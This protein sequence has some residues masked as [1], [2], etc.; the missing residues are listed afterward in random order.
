MRLTERLKQLSNPIDWSYTEK[1]LLGIGLNTS[2]FALFFLIASVSL[3][4]PEFRSASNPAA[5]TFT[6]Y[7]SLGC[8][9]MWGILFVI[10]YRLR[11][12]D[13]DAMRAALRDY[14]HATFSRYE[15]LFEVLTCDE[16]YY[17]KP[18]SLRHPLIF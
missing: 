7:F 8:M 17:R 13:P 16:A 9:A 6:W 5:L 18:I 4:V 12:R 15:Q 2:L 3:L 10:V 1:T 11:Q 14:F